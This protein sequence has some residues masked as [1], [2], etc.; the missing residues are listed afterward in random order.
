MPARTLVLDALSRSALFF[1]A[2]LPRKIYPPL[3]NRYGGEANSFG[4]HIDNSVRTHAASATHVRTDLSGHAV[5]RRT[6]R[7]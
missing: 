5:P 2:A 1:T 7:I 6:R 4:N 3:F